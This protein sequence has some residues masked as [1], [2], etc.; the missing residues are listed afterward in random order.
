[1]FDREVT[2]EQWKAQ[3]YRLAR[4]IPRL[5]I[6]SRPKGVVD[7]YDVSDDWLPIYDKSDLGDSTWPSARAVMNS[8]TLRAWVTSWQG[9]IEACE[10]GRDHDRDPLHVT[11][12]NKGLE[13][14]VGFFRGSG[15]STPT[16]AS[17]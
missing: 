5:R 13:L 16:A 15:R 1:M 2:E 10:A 6:P 8:R 3:V 7:L 14:N 17:L 4:R 12:P 11:T 9:L